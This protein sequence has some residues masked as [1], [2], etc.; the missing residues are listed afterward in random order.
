MR[1]RHGYIGQILF[2]LRQKHAMLSRC[3]ELSLVL[4]IE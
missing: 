1:Q 4:G 3:Y 2:S